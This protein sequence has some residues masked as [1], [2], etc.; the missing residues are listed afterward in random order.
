MSVDDGYTK[1]LLH[2][3]GAASSTSFIDESKKIWTSRGPTLN[4]D[5]K[6]FGVSAALFI[7]NQIDT[8]ANSDFSPGTSDWTID[9]WI[10]RC[11]DMANNATVVVADA[12]GTGWQITFGSTLN[13]FKFTSKATGTWANNI[14][15]TTAIA[16]ITWTHFALVRYVDTLTMYINGTSAGSFN[17]A[18]LSFTETGS[19]FVVGGGLI[20]W[21]DEFRFSK[22]IARWTSNFTPP[23]SDYRPKTG[24][25]A[26]Y[27]SD[28]GFM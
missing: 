2:F 28:F 10:F 11:G 1:S 3:D 6:K 27:L 26:V 17:C 22:G 7:S 15:S 21:I 9:F 4:T 5:Q 8:P 23:V 13:A 20:G 24:E 12:G 19:V 14:D 25:T 16:D 18:G